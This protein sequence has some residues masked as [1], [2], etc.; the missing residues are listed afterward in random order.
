MAQLVE[1]LDL[2]SSVRWFEI[3][4]RQAMRCFLQQDTLSAALY[5][6]DLQHNTTI[7]LPY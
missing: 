4:R 2:G 7:I 1:C 5:W 3:H 6:F